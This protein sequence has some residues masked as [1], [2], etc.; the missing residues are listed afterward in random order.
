MIPALLL[1]EMLDIRGMVS[2]RQSK[3]RKSA[4]APAPD[5]IHLWDCC[6][7]VL[8]VSVPAACMCEFS[9]V[10]VLICVAWGEVLETSCMFFSLQ[11]RQLVQVGIQ[12]PLRRKALILRVSGFYTLTSDT[13]ACK[14]MQTK[15]KPF[16]RELCLLVRS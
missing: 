11:A 14:L 5:S 15:N 13:K 12:T 7:R 4:K 6:G 3:W 16:N 1:T 2:Q 10:C 8:V 9:G